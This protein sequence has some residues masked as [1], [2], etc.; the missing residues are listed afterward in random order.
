[1]QYRVILTSILLVFSLCLFSTYAFAEGANEGGLDLRF[2]LAGDVLRLKYDI[3]LSGG[4]VT[5]SDSS[6][7]AHYN[8]MMGKFAIGYR[9][10]MGGI[11]LEQDMGGVW[12]DDHD[13]N[14]ESNFLGGTFLVGRFILPATDSLQFELGAGVGLMYGSENDSKDIPSLIVDKEGNPSVAFAVKATLGMNFYI[15]RSFGMGVFCDYNYAFKQ[16]SESRTISGI[17]VTGEVTAHYHNVTP[18][19]QFMLKF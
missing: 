9:W 14:G 1:M 10:S 12:Y 2:G 19:L 16:Y 5:A 8:G 6:D 13:V 17:I 4:G 11:Y 15:T 7:Y 3:S 18:G